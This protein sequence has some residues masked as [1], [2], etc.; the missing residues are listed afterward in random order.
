MTV[1]SDFAG[2]TKNSKRTSVENPWTTKQHQTEGHQGIFQNWRLFR[3]VFVS[4]NNHPEMWHLQQHLY[5]KTK[6]QACIQN[7]SHKL[8]SNNLFL[9]LLRTNTKRLQV[10]KIWVK[11]ISSLKVMLQPR[12]CTSNHNQILTPKKKKEKRERERESSGIIQHA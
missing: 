4:G 11:P 1:T 9:V 12:R 8:F 10:S 6:V 5:H 7:F 3:L 2:P